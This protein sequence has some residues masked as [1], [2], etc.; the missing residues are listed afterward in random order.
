MPLPSQ[1]FQARWLFLPCQL[2]EGPSQPRAP[3]SQTIACLLEALLS[4]KK[5]NAYDK[6]STKKLHY[7]KFIIKI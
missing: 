6:R 3:L 5:K 2:L 4:N 7:A 1:I